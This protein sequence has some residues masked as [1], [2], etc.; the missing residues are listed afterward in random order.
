MY[1]HLHLICWNISEVLHGSTSIKMMN[2]KEITI[3]IDPGLLRRGSMSI[4]MS[5]QTEKTSFTF[6]YSSSTPCYWSVVMLKSNPRHATVLSKWSVMW[7]CFVLL[8][9]VIQSGDLLR[10]VTRFFKGK[11][12]ACHLL[13]PVSHSSQFRSDIVWSIS[14]WE[15]VCFFLTSH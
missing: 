8:M 5:L 3:S 12:W 10:I 13:H 6:R 7:G 15:G 14:L 9:F 1:W 2:L 4:S 11:L